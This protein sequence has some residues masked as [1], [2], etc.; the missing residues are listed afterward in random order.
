MTKINPSSYEILFESET[1]FE[2]WIQL[3]LNSEMN[4]GELSRQLKRSKS[5]IH[6]HL[7]KLLKAG[8]ITEIRK[9]YVKGRIPSKYYS[10]DIDYFIK[11]SE[12]PEIPSKTVQ[13]DIQSAI[14][15][16][17]RQKVFARM[18][19]KLLEYKMKFHNHMEKKLLSENPEIQEKYLEIFNSMRLSKIEGE[20]T[21]LTSDIIDYI[22]F[23]SD[24][25]YY[26]FMVDFLRLGE[27]YELKQMELLKKNP[28]MKQDFIISLISLPIRKIQRELKHNFLSFNRKNTPSFR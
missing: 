28:K 18:N 14:K 5:T 19:Q 2:I 13:M 4:L 25:L 6:E 10:L 1:R 27:K 3:S 24:E 8:L 11:L 15:H 26:D 9:E 21:R 7:K 16:I 22:E 20:S 12:S 23:Y 17:S